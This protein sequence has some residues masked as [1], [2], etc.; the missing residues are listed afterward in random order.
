[1]VSKLGIVNFKVPWK[2]KFFQAVF[3]FVVLILKKL[4]LVSC[5]LLNIFQGWEGFHKLSH[6]KPLGCF[7]RFAKYQSFR[8]KYLNI[9]TG[10]V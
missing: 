4:I 9:V 3:V 10:S 7:P 2:L 5:L 1:M 8:L 6:L